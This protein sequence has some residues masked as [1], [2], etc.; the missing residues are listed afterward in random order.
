MH[1]Q[2]A[3]KIDHDGNVIIDIAV[4]FTS[5]ERLEEQLAGLKVADTIKNHCSLFLNSPRLTITT[6]FITPTFLYLFSN[7]TFIITAI[8]FYSSSSTQQ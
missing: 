2:L 5:M 3:K 4:V 8:S 7:S 1:S 6:K